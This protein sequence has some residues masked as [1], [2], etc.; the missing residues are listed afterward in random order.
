MIGPYTQNGPGVT[1]PNRNTEAVMS[2][3][4]GN[5]RSLP[6]HGKGISMTAEPIARK[7]I[8]VQRCDDLG[9]SPP[10]TLRG[11]EKW[12]LE[13]LINAGKAGCTP[14]TT[15][16]PRWSH[17]VWKLRGHGFKIETIHEPHDGPFP[18]H[19]AR[20]VLHSDVQIL[21]EAA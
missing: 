16:G 1:S 19:H 21:E 8:R 11:R 4:A 3:K 15:P 7:T 2:S 14:I 13:K 18:G 6:S 17:Y 12:A 5:A 10:I 9:G 20:Y